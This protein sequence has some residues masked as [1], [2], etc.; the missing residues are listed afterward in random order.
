[1]DHSLDFISLRAP[2]AWDGELTLDDFRS[3]FGPAA[4][5]LLLTIER[6]VQLITVTCRDMAET[7]EKQGLVDQRHKLVL[8]AIYLRRLLGKAGLIERRPMQL[9]VA[10][11]LTVD[12][13]ASHRRLDVATLQVYDSGQLT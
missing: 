1:M 6:A 8:Q 12:A 7:T 4:I 3:H 11:K 9:I 10:G 13:L 2:P 5:E